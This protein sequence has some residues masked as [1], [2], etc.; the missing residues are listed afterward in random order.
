MAR[1]I[2]TSRQAWLGGLMI[3]SSYVAS[4]C[5]S[6][7]TACFPVLCKKYNLGR[8]ETHD[9]SMEKCELIKRRGA[10]RERTYMIYLVRST[11]PTY[12]LRNKDAQLRVL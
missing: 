3:S 4:K 6:C 8:V 12:I 5:S 11:S 10:G 1:T 7:Y 9:T 2:C